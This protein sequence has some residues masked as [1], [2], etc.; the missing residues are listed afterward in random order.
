M[1]V[2]L[3]ASTLQISG[4][5]SSLI[6]TRAGHNGHSAASTMSRPIGPLHSRSQTRHN[7]TIGR[8]SET[9]T[10]AEHCGISGPARFGCSIAAENL[11]DSANIRMYTTLNALTSLRFSVPTAKR[12][13]R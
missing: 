8:S 4:F 11:I 6:Q 1:S 10:A 3:S 7:S 2:G 13:F 5:T 9:L 12:V